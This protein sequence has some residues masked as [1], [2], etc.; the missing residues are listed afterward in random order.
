[1][2]RRAFLSTAAAAATSLSWP[3]GAAP[4]SRI[5]KRDRMLQ[6]L[7]GKTDRAYTPAAFFLHFG[8]EYR[9]GLPAAQ[10]HTEFFKT[11]NMDFVKI[12]FEQT[13]EPQPFLQTPADWSKLKL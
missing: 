11:T 4:A 9:N 5:S 13:Y 7:A 3:T 2:N 1:M 12:Q 10:R 8:P 6:W